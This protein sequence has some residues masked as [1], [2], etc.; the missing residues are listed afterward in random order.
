MHTQACNFKPSLYRSV[1][2]R[3]VNT[4]AISQVKAKM[5]DEF[6]IKED[7]GLVSFNPL[8]PLELPGKKESQ[9]WD[10]VHQVVLGVCLWDIFLVKDCGQR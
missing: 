1:F 2:P 6:V 9:L 3:S 8:D 7:N 4:D 10:C 5:E